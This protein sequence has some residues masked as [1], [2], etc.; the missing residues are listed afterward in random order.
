MAGKGI[1]KVGNRYDVDINTNQFE[2]VADDEN[3]VLTLSALNTAGT[4]LTLLGSGQ[5]GTTLNADGNFSVATS[6]F[7]VDATTGNTNAAGTLNADGNLSVAT[8]QFTVDSTTGNTNAAG[9][10][11]A[12]GNLS[13]ATS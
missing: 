10:L 9:T 2:F 8:T 6:Q 11:N 7:T 3:G 1:V 4:D 13:V 5:F 12:D